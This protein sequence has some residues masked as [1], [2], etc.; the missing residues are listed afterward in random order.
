VRGGFLGACAL[1]VALSMGCGTSKPLGGAP[2]AAGTEGAAGTGGAAGTSGAAGAAG[3]VGAA[4]ATGGESGGTGGD[5]GTAGAADGGAAD[6]IETEAGACSIAAAKH[7]DE[8]A[9][10]VPCLP[11]PTYGTKPPSSGNHYQIW[12]DFKTY[13]T[14]VPWGHLVHALEHGAIVI[15]YN[16]PGG[17]P[18]EVAQA[19]AMIDALPTDPLCTAPTKHRVILAPDPTLDVR[20]AAS[21]WTW[22]LRASCFDAAAFHDF[23]TAHY[24][25][26]GEDLCG[27]LHEPFC[28]TP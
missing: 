10:H 8:G 11:V 19:Q 1:A 15:V 12:A 2:G 13:A 28:V 3:T 7:P 9:F 23:A 17:C 25:M 6:V 27:E 22:T 24:G 16:C 14:P 26:G 4:G 21:A 18:D 20:W 5:P